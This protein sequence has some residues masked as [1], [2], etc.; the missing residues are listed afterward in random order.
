[1]RLLAAL[2]LAAFLPARPAAGCQCV[3]SSP[4]AQ[5]EAA[6]IVVVGRAGKELTRDTSVVQPIAVLHALK[7]KPGPVLTLR[8]RAEALTPCDRLFAEHEVALVFAT[9]GAVGS[10]AGNHP[11]QVQ[12]RHLAEYFAASASPSGAS[13]RAAVELALARVAAPIL[14]GRERVDVT[15]PRLAGKVFRIGKTRLRFIKPRTSTGVVIDHAVASGPVHFIAGT[16]LREGRTFRVVVHDTGSALQVLG[17][18]TEKVR[19]P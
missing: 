12:S 3:V 9:K 13:S 16:L 6:D 19:T 14:V 5:V 1:M 18:W 17:A 15:L 8:R 11:L 2:L 4:H 7:G 10:C